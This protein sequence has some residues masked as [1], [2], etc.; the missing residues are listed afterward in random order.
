MSTTT[1]RASPTSN[2]S[3]IPKEEEREQRISRDALETTVTML[4]ERTQSMEMSEIIHALDPPQISEEGGQVKNE[5]LALHRSSSI[6]SITNNDN[7]D[8][9]DAEAQEAN[10]NPSS[11]SNSDSDSSDDLEAA[12]TAELE[13]DEDPTIDRKP[14]STPPSPVPS[15]LP[16]VTTSPALP[17][18][19]SKPSFQT[20]MVYLAA[21]Y[22][23]WEMVYQCV[24]CE[25]DVRIRGGGQ[26]RNNLSGGS[27]ETLRCRDCGCRILLKK[28]TRRA[29]QFEAR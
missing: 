7:N 11:A 21:E 20:G 9:Q 14:T 26:V 24:E 27:M 4:K 22:K 19:A 25:G 18:V 6:V 3:S 13:I 2:I 17:P 16:M 29:V 5:E 10:N 23:P 12:F 28:R 15:P 8:A 1:D